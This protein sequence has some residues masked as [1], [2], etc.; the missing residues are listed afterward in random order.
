MIP[1]LRSQKFS[2]FLLESKIEIEKYKYLNLSSL[3]LSLLNNYIPPVHY[4][5]DKNITIQ[6]IISLW[7]QATRC[8]YQ[9]IHVSMGIR[10]TLCSVFKESK[11]KQFLIPNDIYPYYKQAS[12]YY[13]IKSKYYD[14]NKKCMIYFSKYLQQDNSD[15]LLL[16]DPHCM[17]NIDYDYDGILLWLQKDKN[18][19]LIVDGVYN[20]S[21]YNKYDKLLLSNQTILSFSLSK[22]WLLPMTF[23]L[24]IVPDNLIHL[25]KNVSIPDQKSIQ[26]AYER[27]SEYRYMPL[28]QEQIFQDIWKSYD[29]TNY[30][31]YLKIDMN[32]TPQQYKKDKKY[33]IPSE[34]YDIQDKSIL[35]ILD[36]INKKYKQGS[37]IFSKTRYHVTPLSNFAKNYDK[38]TQRYTKQKNI[39]FTYPDQFHLT[40]LDTIM[41][42]INKCEGLLK[43]LNII[44]D[45]ILIMETCITEKLY[46]KNQTEY[47]NKNH[48]KIKSL[49]YLDD[50]NNFVSMIIE[51]VYAESL[52]LQ[53]TYRWKDLIPKTIS[54]LPIAK[55]CQAKCSFCFSHSSISSDM[56]QRLLNHNTINNVLFI[57]KQNGATR[58]V[59][60]GG[61]EPTMLRFDKLLEIINLCSM[62]FDKCVLITN[63][64]FFGKKN[65]ETMK[66]YLNML[67]D[68]G[69][70]ILSVSRHGYDNIT[71]TKIMNLD[72][73]SELISLGINACKSDNEKFILSL[74]WICV[75]QKGGVENIETLEK[76]MDWVVLKTCSKQ[77]CFKELYVASHQESVYYNAD[78]NKWSYDHQ[79]SLEFVNEWCLNNGG[80]IKN[81][82]E[83]GAPIYELTWKNRIMMIAVYTEPSV[84]WELTSKT[85]RSWN[86]MANSELYASLEDKNSL[87]ELK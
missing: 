31:K 76:Y 34:I 60:T 43:K 37:F 47:I 8:K 27:I 46:T 59:I 25:L 1:H 57:A 22:A 53:K 52:K 84:Y 15:I 18:R 63:G 10:D 55:G 7:K 65:I 24:N 12:E 35:S 21:I 13:N 83:W 6:T 44:G 48:I 17:N 51:D 56:N 32:K 66:K 33:V 85:C 16:T 49:Y 26:K 20:Y 67:E 87:L 30:S 72:T 23:G 28:E 61:G 86:L 36:L 3:D 82:L 5:S 4:I 29:N 54:I 11:N 42:G 64:Y 74:R 77:V 78:Y 14:T 79:V 58:A 38:Y 19:T 80:K 41:I 2:Q 45:K 70:N 71:N 50:Q 81:Q 40:S 9:N 75:I 68:S 69:L 73:K 62:Y 39:N